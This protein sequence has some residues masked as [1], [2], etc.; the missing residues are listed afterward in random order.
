M[1]YNLLSHAFTHSLSLFLDT[2]MSW[3]LGS[4]YTVLTKLIVSS[5]AS[6]WWHTRWW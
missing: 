4:V 2:T 6:Q 1:R 3:C 5:M